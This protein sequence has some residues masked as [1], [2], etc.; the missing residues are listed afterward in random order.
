MTINNVENMSTFELLYFFT[1][2][3]GS[4]NVYIGCAEQV[5]KD[6]IKIFQSGSSV[7]VFWTYICLVGYYLI[8][9][10]MTVWIYEHICDWHT[11][12]HF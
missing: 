12:K 9:S 11:I 6:V 1:L 3:G 5:K 8:N 10:K 4:M 2:Y 7:D